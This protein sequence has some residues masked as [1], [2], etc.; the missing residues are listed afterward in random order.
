MRFRIRQ[1]VGS[2]GGGL[3]KEGRST[4][5]GEGEDPKISSVCPASFT[6]PTKRRDVMEFTNARHGS[7]L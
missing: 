1:L 5:R 6:L 7:L 4:I 3:K 2:V